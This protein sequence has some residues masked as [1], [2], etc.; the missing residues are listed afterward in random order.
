MNIRSKNIVSGSPNHSEKS[1]SASSTHSIGAYIE[2]VFKKPYSTSLSSS[3]S[4]SSSCTWEL[5]T[6]SSSSS[7]EQSSLPKPTLSSPSSSTSEWEWEWECNY[8]ECDGKDSSEILSTEE[9]FNHRLAAKTRQKKTQ[10]RRY[11]TFLKR[12]SLRALLGIF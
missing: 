3:S 4:S 2:K 1:V 9:W 7:S 12:D 5:P 10:Q 11:I 8:L 6:P